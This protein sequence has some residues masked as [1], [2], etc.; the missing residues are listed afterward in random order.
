MKFDIWRL[1]KRRFL[2]DESAAVISP[3]RLYRFARSHVIRG[4]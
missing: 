3:A 4:E 2:F 1:V